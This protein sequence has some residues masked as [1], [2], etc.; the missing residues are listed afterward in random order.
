MS[1]SVPRHFS[2][3]P[4]AALLRTPPERPVLLTAGCGATDVATRRVGKD[5]SRRKHRPTAQLF[6]GR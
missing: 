1:M 4:T 5:V 6:L 3:S 2:A